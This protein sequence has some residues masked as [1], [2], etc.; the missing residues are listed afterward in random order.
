[1]TILSG[2]T[3]IKFDG[4]YDLVKVKIDG[5]ERSILPFNRRK[6]LD[7]RPDPNAVMAIDSFFPGTVIDLKFYLDRQYLSRFVKEK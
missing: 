4:K 6:S 3:L 5:E 2:S 7:K 1:M